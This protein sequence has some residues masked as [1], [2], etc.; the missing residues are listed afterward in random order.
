MKSSL[1]VEQLGKS[2]ANHAS[3]QFGQI[4]LGLPMGDGQ[5]SE[6]FLAN[7]WFNRFDPFEGEVNDPQSLHK[8]AYVHGDPIQGIDP[9]G[10]QFSVTG[11]VGAIGIGAGLGGLIGAGVGAVSD[12]ITVR[13]GALY[14]AGAGA[15]IAG[16]VYSGAWA[17]G[18]KGIGRFFYD[19]RAFS[20]IS[21]QYW[22]QFGPA[23]GASLHHWLI[24]Q[25][26]TWVSE[27]FRNAG[28]NLLQL[29]KI[30]P[31]N[32]GLNQWMGFALRWGGQ[33]MVMAVTIENGIRIAIPIS[34]STAGG[35]GAWIGEEV[36]TDAIDLGQGASATPLDLTELQALQMQ[37]EAARMLIDEL[38]AEF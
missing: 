10:R 27:G 7:G 6:R 20:T 26:W 1:S 36:V 19:P 15:I 30:L 13:Q 34:I 38:D 25:R 2:R 21:R 32:L 24:P 37:E 11:L 14:G 35:I 29:P 28:F 31:G 9:S 3:K 12:N 33:R 17:T 5:Q 4:R 8:Y 22:A 16:L 23:N 18:A